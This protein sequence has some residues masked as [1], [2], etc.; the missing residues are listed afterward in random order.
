PYDAVSL[1]DQCQRFFVLAPTLRVFRRIPVWVGGDRGQ[2][3]SFGLQ[4]VLISWIARSSC[5]SSPLNSFAGSLSTTMSGSTPW[6]SMIH[7][8]P[9]FEYGANSGLKNWPPSASGSDSRIPI[10]PP[11][12]RF[13]INLPS[14]SA[15]K[16]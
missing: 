6:P 16:R 4:L 15:L 10:T 14:P 8:L 3:V 1:R 2:V 5:W 12:V 7:C 11:H 13:P 9:S